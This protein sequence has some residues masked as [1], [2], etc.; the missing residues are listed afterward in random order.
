MGLKTADS[1][2][3]DPATFLDTPYLDRIK[4]L[5]RHRV[6]YGFGTPEDHALIHV[7]RL[8]FLYALVGVLLATLTSGLNP[9]HLTSWWTEPIVYQKLVL[10]TMLLEAVGFGGSGGRFPDTSSR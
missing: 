7:A 6:D 8:V 9:L 4:V 3:V 10:W 1:P 5:S 2:P